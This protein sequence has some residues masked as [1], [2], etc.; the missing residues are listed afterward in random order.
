TPLHRA[1]ATGNLAVLMALLRY[2]SI[3]V[4]DVDRFGRSILWHAACGGNEEVIQILV[5]HGARIDLADDYG[6]TPLHAA[7]RE[8]RVSSVEALLNAG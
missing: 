8:G 1:A 3:D 2:P 4:N 5:S 6:R 7:C